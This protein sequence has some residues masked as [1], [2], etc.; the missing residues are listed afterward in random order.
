MWASAVRLPRP[1]R[2]PTRARL[3]G[4][5]LAPEIGVH[6]SDF[7]IENSGTSPQTVTRNTAAS[8]SSILAILFGEFTN[9][10]APSD[11]KGNTYTL[12]EN[13]GYFDLWAGFG[14]ELYGKANAAGGSSHALSMTK[15]TTTSESTLMLVE[16]LGTVIQ[17]T[18]I[19][20]RQR[21]GAG[22]PYSS[23]SVTTTGPALLVSIWGGDGDTNFTDQ[24]ATPEAGFEVIE[25]LF[26]GQTAYI[27][28][29]CAVK[30]VNAAGTYTCAWT[31][32]QNQGGIVALAAIQA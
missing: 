3:V 6:G 5:V 17:D 14:L 9:C 25:S 12:L 22:V 19:V 32:T 10:S 30:R 15:T 27:Q 23:A 1:A 24:S 26:L 16:A 2:V 4:G 28:A 18:S 7:D 20:A 21:Q 13:S 31:P 8:G 29:A 11:N